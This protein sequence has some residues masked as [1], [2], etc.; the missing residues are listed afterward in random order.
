M[1][2]GMSRITYAWVV[3]G[4]IYVYSNNIGLQIVI[5]SWGYIVCPTSITL[6]GRVQYMFRW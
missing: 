6:L 3:W 1:E 5:F 2:I 4:R